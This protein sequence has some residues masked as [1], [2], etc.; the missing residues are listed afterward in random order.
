M[1]SLSARPC[2]AAV[3]ILCASTTTQQPTG[4]YLN[5][6]S[7]SSSGSKPNKGE[8]EREEDALKLPS[9]LDGER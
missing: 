5:G 2:L 9:V 4:L 3:T 7:R 6:A 1:L 8:E